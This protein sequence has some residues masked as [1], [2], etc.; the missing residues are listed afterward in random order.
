MHVGSSVCA[1]TNGLVVY[2][3]R[4]SEAVFKCLSSLI[5]AVYQEQ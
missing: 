3:P 2:F 1:I 5:R 4:G